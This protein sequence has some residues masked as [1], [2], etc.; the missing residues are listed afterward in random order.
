MVPHVAARMAGLVFPF[1]CGFSSFTR[2]LQP[3]YVATGSQKAAF[4]KDEP[5]CASA[6]LASDCIALANVP[7]AKA[8]H[9][10]KPR[11]SMGGDYIQ[12]FEYQ[13]LRFIGGHL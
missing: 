8:S 13:D 12:G 3:S 1:P 7:L 2:L 6:Y 5:Q 9:M 11:V 4:Q 10:A